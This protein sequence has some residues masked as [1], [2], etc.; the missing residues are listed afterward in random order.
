MRI[1]IISDLHID[2]YN[3]SVEN[4]HLYEGALAEEIR[5]RQI[6]MLLIAG[7]ISNSYE[8]TMDFIHTISKESGVKIKFVPGNHDL[9]QS[10]MSKSTEEILQRYADQ[11]EC[12]IRRPYILNDEWAIAGHTG[13]YDYSYASDRFTYERLSRR[14]Y[15]GGT[16]QDKE[17][18]DWRHS[19][20]II[21]EKFA[22]EVRKD[23]ESLEGRKIIL[24]THVV[25]NKHFKVPMPHRLFDYYNAFIG[26][27]DFDK[28]YDDYDIRYSI[29]GHVHFRHSLTEGSVT[30][31]CPCLGYKREWRTDDIRTEMGNS[32]YVIEI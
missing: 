24:V 18:I 12:L 19:D 9:W 8:L 11:P 15:Y 4:I 22:D 32:M 29:M 31:I 30:Y 10:D 6:D 26:T 28:I 13:W 20:D 14:A 3:N 17:N 2:R 5:N 25:T 7:D 21:S 27:S 23:L 16:W 1:G